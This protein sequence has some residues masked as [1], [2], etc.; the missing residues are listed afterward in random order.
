MDYRD[1][2]WAKGHVCGDDH[3]CIVHAFVPP[4]LNNRENRELVDVRVVLPHTVKTQVSR[5]KK[6]NK[7]ETKRQRKVT[8][9]REQGKGSDGLWP[10]RNLLRRIGVL[11]NPGSDFRKQQNASGSVNSDRAPRTLSHPAAEIGP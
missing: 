7:T 2:E 11:A 1:N 8:E 10:F 3:P 5:A 6:N 4:T 9:S